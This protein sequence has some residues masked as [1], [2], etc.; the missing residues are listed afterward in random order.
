MEKSM[1]MTWNWNRMNLIFYDV[2]KREVSR[3][4][5][6]YY[7]ELRWRHWKNYRVSQKKFSLLKIHSFKSTSQNLNDSNYS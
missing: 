7:L 1:L 4:H 5:D 6:C 2:T 3:L